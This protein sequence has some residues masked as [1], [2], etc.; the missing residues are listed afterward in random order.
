MATIFEMTKTKERFTGYLSVFTS[1]ILYRLKYSHIVSCEKDNWKIIRLTE[2]K[3][4]T[5]T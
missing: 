5:T 1:N 2:E 3:M 4:E